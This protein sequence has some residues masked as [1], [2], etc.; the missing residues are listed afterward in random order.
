MVTG[1]PEAS[2]RMVSFLIFASPRTAKS[3]RWLPSAP[4]SA[5]VR[6]PNVLMRSFRMFSATGEICGGASGWSASRVV[7][8]TD[9]LGSPLARII[10]TR[11]SRD[12]SL[13]DFCSA[14][15]LTTASWSP[16]S[17]VLADARSLVHDRLDVVV[18][19]HKQLG[20]QQV[21]VLIERLGVEQQPKRLGNDLALRIG[22]RI[23]C[24]GAL[25]PL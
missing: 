5:Q 21:V 7:T 20:L 1:R 2:S 22:A 14:L 24:C 4:P 3:A 15:T 16:T 18:A 19:V 8:C 9:T 10:S 6:N 11:S 13:S 12:I 25:S 23:G 17:A